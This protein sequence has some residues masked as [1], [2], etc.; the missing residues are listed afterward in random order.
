MLEAVC[1]YLKRPVLIDQILEPSA[2]EQRP[3]GGCVFWIAIDDDHPVWMC[4]A[5]VDELLLTTVD[6]RLLW[7]IGCRGVFPDVDVD[8]VVLTAGRLMNS[9]VR[10]YLAL[11]L[12]HR[13]SELYLRVLQM[14]D[15]KD[16]PVWWTHPVIVD[17]VSCMECDAIAIGQPRIDWFDASHPTFLVLFVASSADGVDSLEQLGVIETAPLEC[18]RDSV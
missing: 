17:A 15:A 8:D 12:L 4:V 6:D 14:T 7:A 9:R 1:R 16:M 18:C 5:V 10:A 2:L 3:V 11:P 13:V